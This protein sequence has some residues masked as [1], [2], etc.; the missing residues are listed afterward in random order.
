MSLKERGYGTMDTY[1]LIFD[2][3][4][5]RKKII[6][7]MT[8]SLVFVLLIVVILSYLYAN[9]K[10]KALFN[11][12]QL[13]LEKDQNIRDQLTGLVLNKKHIERMYNES[14]YFFSSVKQMKSDYLSLK[15]YFIWTGISEE[16]DKIEKNLA[17]LQ[18]LTIEELYPLIV[19]LADRNEKINIKKKAL[20]RSSQLSVNEISNNLNKQ[21]EIVELVGMSIEDAKKIKNHQLR[22]MFN[23]IDPDLKPDILEKRREEEERIKEQI[24]RD[25]ARASE[26]AKAKSHPPSPPSPSSYTTSTTPASKPVRVL[27]IPGLYRKN[28]SLEEQTNKIGKDIKDFFSGNTNKK[29]DDVSVSIF[30]IT[31]RR[32]QDIVFTVTVRN[33]SRQTVRNVTISVRLPYTLSPTFA[34]PIPELPPGNSAKQYFIFVAPRLAG[35]Y[36][37]KAEVVW[38]GKLYNRTSARFKVVK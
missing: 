28:P 23:D 22:S 32:N 31:A 38:N 26:L 34:P 5:K 25:L 27:P 10:A 17:A 3:F 18:T 37:M 4:K 13:A 24:H 29:S 30:D 6:R 12:S 16:L 36:P 21:K 1:D 11:A 20:S 9:N 35:N 19:N 14:S 33:R 7:I 8:V 15:K 2:P